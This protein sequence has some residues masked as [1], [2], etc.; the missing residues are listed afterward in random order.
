MSAKKDPNS[1]KKKSSD[2]KGFIYCFLLIISV[3]AMWVGYPY[4][5]PY[6]HTITNAATYGTFGDSFGAL[7]TLFSGL[8]FATLIITLFLQRKELQLQRE[9]VQESNDIAKTQ[10]AISDQQ[11]QL[12]SQQIRES[13][14]QNFYNLFLKFIDEKNLKKNNLVINDRFNRGINMYGNDVFK[15]FAYNFI[16]NLDKSFIPTPPKED[17]SHYS[18]SEEFIEKLSESYERSSVNF[19]IKFEETYYFEYVEFILNFIKQNESLIDINH[20]IKI[21]LSYFTFHETICMACISLTKMP[22]LKTYIN[23]LGLLRNINPELLTSD[24]YA[25]LKSLFDESAFKKIA[26]TTANLNF[27]FESD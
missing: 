7:N 10:S 26:G 23:E 27:L 15:Q 19:S 6:L 20:V 11:A 18:E 14:K 12:I 9:E 8:A 4:G 22:S 16:G 1:K 17:G 13:Q 5:L 2:W 25:S 3:F 24:Q 21:F